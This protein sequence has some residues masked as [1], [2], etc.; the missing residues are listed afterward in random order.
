MLSSDELTDVVR[1]REA[2]R[3]GEFADHRQFFLGKHD[4][5]LVRSL[6]SHLQRMYILGVPTMPK[7]KRAM[8][9]VPSA[10]G[11]LPRSGDDR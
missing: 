8:N 3:L 6:R 5:K 2:V 11:K 9:A 4:V 7:P 10:G 1:R